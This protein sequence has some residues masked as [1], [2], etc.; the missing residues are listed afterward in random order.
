MK[1]GTSNTMAVSEQS[2]WLTP[3]PGGGDRA[4]YIGDCRADCW[5]GFAMGAQQDNRIFNLTCVIHPLNMK[6][7]AGFGI[8]GNCGPNTPIQSAHPNGVQSLFADGSVQ[9]LSETLDIN[10]LYHLADRDDGYTVTNAF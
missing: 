8:Q 2:D 9:F 3:P 1:D 10:T 6:S 5:H 7:T 4:Y